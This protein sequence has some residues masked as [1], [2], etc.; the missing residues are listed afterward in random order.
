MSFSLSLSLS[1]SLSFQHFQEDAELAAKLEGL[2]D[3]AYMSPLLKMN[4]KNA[5]VEASSM[6]TLQKEAKEEYSDVLE[7]MNPQSPVHLVSPPITGLV[8]VM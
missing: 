3:H 2:L 4:E 1:L 8:L 7:F 5:A 6:Y